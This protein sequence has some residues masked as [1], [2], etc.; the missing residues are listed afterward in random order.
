MNSFEK[1]K[2]K[3]EF[4]QGL[5]QEKDLPK[6]IKQELKELYLKEMEAYFNE[7]IFLKRK[8]ELK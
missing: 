1:Y 4:E 2:L 7:Y 8:Y 6:E 3:N 5:I